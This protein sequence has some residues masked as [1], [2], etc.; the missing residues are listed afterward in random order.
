M[1]CLDT[2]ITV[3]VVMSCVNAG[4]PDPI[5][6]ALNDEMKENDTVSASCS[7]SHSCPNSPPVFKWSH[8]GEEHH[9]SHQLSDGRWNA[10]SVLTF[11]LMHA[12]HNKPLQC[13]VTHKGGQQQKQSKILQV[14]CE[15]S[16]HLLS[17]KTTASEENQ[18]K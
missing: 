15:C 1:Q 14:K 10:T 3:T 4:E 11:H 16:S 5:R 7:V 13:S 2:T 12:D 9:L 6:F 18:I 17:H 8:S